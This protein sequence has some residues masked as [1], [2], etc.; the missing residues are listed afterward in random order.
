MLA[1]ARFSTGSSSVSHLH[2]HRFV[3][4]NLS[5]T[6]PNLAAIVE[7]CEDELHPSAVDKYLALNGENQSLIPKSLRTCTLPET[8]GYL[9]VATQIHH[10]NGGFDERNEVMS[11]RSLSDDWNRHMESTKPCILRQK[12]TIFVEAPLVSRMDDLPGLAAGRTSVGK[13]QEENR[14]DD[15]IY[16]FR[17]Y[18]LKLGYD[19]VPKFLDMY[20]GGLP[21]KLEAEGTDPTTNLIT[22]LYSECGPLNEIIEIWRHGAGTTAMDRSRVAARKATEWRSAIANIAGLAETFTSTIHRPTDY[23]PLR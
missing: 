17:R 21:S 9:N 18:Q 20:E 10:Y 3:R 7:L 8:G 11:A 12:S 22:L 2:C 19:T 6:M 14:D 4:R 13:Q 16:E 15:C 1:S 5:S 23:S